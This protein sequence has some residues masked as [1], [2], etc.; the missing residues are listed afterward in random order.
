M[1][2]YV[3]NS[4]VSPHSRM[5][6]WLSEKQL[7]SQQQIISQFC[8]SFQQP[9]TVVLFNV[10]FSLGL[11]VLLVT[12]LVGRELFFCSL[13][14]WGWSFYKCRTDFNLCIMHLLKVLLPG[15]SPPQWKPSVL[16]VNKGR[17]AWGFHAAVVSS[18][19]V[20]ACLVLRTSFPAQGFL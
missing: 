2:R 9:I 10:Y 14:F 5:F 1:E 7:I 18:C 13:G 12:L 17:D 20:V 19:H 16:S 4:I 6:M 8:I 11:L 15:F 3:T